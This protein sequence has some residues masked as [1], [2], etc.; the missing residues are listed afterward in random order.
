MSKKAIILAAGM[1][2]RL[3]PMTDNKPKCL[4]ELNGETLVNYQLKCLAKCNI[5]QILLVIGY[6]RDMIIDYITKLNYGDLIKPIYNDVFDKTDNAY[7]VALALDY[8]DPKVDSIVILDGDIIFDIELL[9]RLITSEYNN[10]LVADNTKKIVPDDCKIIVKEGYTRG[11][12]KKARGTTVYTS[13]IKMSGKFL[14]EFKKE[15][16]MPR[17]NPEWYS[18]PLN[19]LLMKYQKEVRVVLTNSLLRCEV[20]TYEDLIQAKEIYRKIMQ[21]YG[22]KNEV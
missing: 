14:E 9:K 7:S 15:V 16:K 4:L 11:I 17:S 18:E 19:R 10:V 22:K 13:M 8:V 20:D 2:K 6:K 21:R 1:S 3:R 5:E 12:G